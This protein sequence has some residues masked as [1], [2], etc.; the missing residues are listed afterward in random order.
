MNS[1]LSVGETLSEVFSLY[2]ENFGLLMPVAFWIFLVVAIVDG[3]TASNNVYLLVLSLAIGTLAGTLYQGVVVNLVRNV[4]D[5]RTDSSISGLVTATLPRVLPL[6][7]AGLISGVAIACGFVLLIVPGLY[8]AT[9]WAVI[10]PVIVV[11]ESDVG[12]SF[13]RS[14]ALVRGNGWPVLGAVFVGG[15]IVVIGGLILTSIAAA[16]ADGAIVRIVFSAIAATITAPI[17]A[18]V[19]AVLYFRLVAIREATLVPTPPP[20]VEPPAL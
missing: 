16:I 14:R 4:H 20:P 5:G 17:S 7:G 11:G 1:R 8:L 2:G 13:S 6:I 15:L 18:L 12:E 3:V 9:I 19:A 10:A